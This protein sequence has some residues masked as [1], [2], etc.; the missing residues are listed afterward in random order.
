MY[1][2]GPE[3][4]ES[5]LDLTKLRYERM[6][7]AVDTT[8]AAFLGLTLGCARCHDHKFDPIPQ[9]DYF[10]LQA[11]FAAS[12]PERITVVD[13]N[14]ASHRD[15]G[16]HFMIAMDEAQIAYR[17]MEKRVKTR[18]IESR[19]NEF[20]DAATKAFAALAPPSAEH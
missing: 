6:T 12:E 19:R 18:V 20:S 1:T 15:E 13:G 2:F 17:L 10:S 3:I 11:V 16:Y 9:K 14:N 8:G 4:Q 5:N 7:D